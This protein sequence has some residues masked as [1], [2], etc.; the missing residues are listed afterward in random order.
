MLGWPDNADRVMFGGRLVLLPGL[1]VFVPDAGPRFAYRGGVARPTAVG[2]PRADIVEAFCSVAS[3]GAE[4][5]VGATIRTD[6]GRDETVH[7]YGMTPQ[8][9]VYGGASRAYASSRPYGA[10]P[11]S[12]DSSGQTTG[13]PGARGDVSRETSSGAGHVSST[14]QSVFWPPR[15]YRHSGRAAAGY[16][17]SSSFPRPTGAT[18]SNPLLRPRSPPK[19]RQGPPPLVPTPHRRRPLRRRRW[20]NPIPDT[21]LPRVRSPW[22]VTRR[23]RRWPWKRCAPCRS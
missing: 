16:P 4:R 15:A 19:L 2:W 6:V 17:G 1:M 12:S 7:E 23:I 18:G 22:K 11:R 13:T 9:S 3:E 10:A 8:R 20:S 14:D 5:P 21:V